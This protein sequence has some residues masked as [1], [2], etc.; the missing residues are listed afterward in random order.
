MSNPPVPTASRRLRSHL[1]AL[2]TGVSLALL[3]ATTVLAAPVDD[4]RA[5]L[6]DYDTFLNQADPIGA[7][8]RGDLEAA[9]RWPDD[10]PKAVADRQ[11]A[12]AQLRDRLTAIPA[13]GLTGQDALNH[14]LLLR[15][16]NLDLESAKFDEERIPFSNDSGFFSV[17]GYMADSTRLRSAAEVEAYLVRMAGLPGY[18]ETEIANMRRGL[19]T[20][21]VQPRLIAETAVRM[22]RTLADVK[23]ED[24]ALLAPLKALPATIPAADREAFLKRGL[25]IVKTKVK[26]AETA[27]VDFFAKEYLPKARATL[28]AASLPDGKAYYAYRVKRETTTTMTPD[29]VYALGQSEIARIRAEMDKVIKQTGF[30]GDFKEFL[31]F[32]RSD[33]QFYATSREQ[34]LEK[35][36]RLA[37]RIDDKLPEYFSLLPRLPYGVRPVPAEIEEGYTSGRYNPGSPEQ[38]VAGGLMINTS[39]LTMRPLYEMPALV[40]HE[41]VPGHHLQIA[42]AQEQKDVPQFRRQDDVTA[43]VEGWALYTEQLVE[44][45]GMYSTP[46]EKFGQLSMEMWRAC[47]L[48]MDTGIHWKG[49]GREEAASCLR[50][51]SALAEKNIQSETDRYIA[52]PGQALGYKIG[53]L[54]ISELRARAE[55]ALGPKFD[56]KQFHALVLNDGP[57]PMT[58][59]EQ[60]IDGWIKAGGGK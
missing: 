51:N 31:A 2:G 33:P 32:L 12:I 53:Q 60:R 17:P 8:L 29:E 56:I 6:S 35:A 25:E 48:V 44:E 9:K 42:L 16:L 15:R 3:S 14:A 7:G 13:A 10:S 46:Y 20:G 28:G 55:K 57:M 24:N 38:G 21:F 5:A 52:W 23:P 36:S 18:Y 27:L 30:K 41:G 37:K 39:H 22:T 50:D 49:M 11:R 34:L 54:K 58:M 1:L 59:V 4:L 19:K 43:F 45:M 40:A 26:P 47:R